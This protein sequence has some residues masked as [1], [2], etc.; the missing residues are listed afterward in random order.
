MPQIDAGVEEN[1]GCAGTLW[2]TRGTIVNRKT[3]G[4]RAT[5]P[6][7]AVFGIAVRMDGARCQKLYPMDTCT[8]PADSPV[9]LSSLWP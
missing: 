7:W 1:S 8:W 5:F 9:S 6:R 3:P 2:Q 4:L